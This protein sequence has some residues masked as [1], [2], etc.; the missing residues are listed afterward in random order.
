MQIGNEETD[1]QVQRWTVQTANEYIERD[2]TKYN[3]DGVVLHRRLFTPCPL[4]GC[5]DNC[6]HRRG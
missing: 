1:D 3:G 2:H 5:Y 6:I 4:L